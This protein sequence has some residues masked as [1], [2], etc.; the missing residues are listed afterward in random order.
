MKG[1]FRRASLAGGR[2]RDHRYIGLLKTLSIVRYKIWPM[3]N[4]RPDVDTLG[5][6][7]RPGVFW[8]LLNETKLMILYGT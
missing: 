4:E 7:G 6:E 8:E 1:T 3:L 2:E 5:R